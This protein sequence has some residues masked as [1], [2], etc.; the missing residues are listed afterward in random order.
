MRNTLRKIHLKEFFGLG[1]FLVGCGLFLL[2]SLGSI[3]EGKTETGVEVPEENI[4]DAVVQFL[5]KTH[6]WS[7]AEV[8][9][10]DVR[11]PGRVVLSGP[12]ENV[13]MRVPSNTRYLGRTSVEIT[14]NGGRSSHK[15]IWVSTYLEVLGPVVVVKRPLARNQI[16][17]AEDIGLEERDLAKVPPGAMTNLNLAVG[18]RAKRTV[19]VG[20]V[21][22][23]AMV[24][25]PMVV[26]RGDVVK[27]MI[28]TARLRITTLGQ[29][30]ERGGIGDTVRVINLDSRKRVYGEVLDS[31]TVRIRY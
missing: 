15:K 17:S 31:R 8:R 12:L 22:R 14:F 6:P 1:F 18:K 13:S 11:I 28:D 29:V 3:A 7:N 21:L 19:G 4:H 5:M 10:R 26:K 16:I 24:D 27:M 20:T 23:T 30:E 25:K 9:V 2:M